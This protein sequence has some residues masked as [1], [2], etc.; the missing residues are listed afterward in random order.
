MIM[1]KR[2][3][4]NST[5]IVKQKLGDDL[6]SIAEFKDMLKNGD[7]SKRSACPRPIYMKISCTI[8]K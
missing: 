4:E 3:L 5:F 1:R 6:L 8:R 2:F 7:K